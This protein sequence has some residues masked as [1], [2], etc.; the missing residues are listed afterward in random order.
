MEQRYN[1]LEISSAN[2]RRM[3]GYAATYNTASNPDALP[4]REKIAP[5]AFRSVLRNS[6]AVMLLNHDASSIL[7]RQSA[8][9]LRLS[10][11]E[12]GLR[13]ECDLPESPLGENVRAACAR[14]DLRECSFGFVVDQDDW[15][16]SDGEAMRTI[17]SFRSLSDC[18]LVT[19]PAYPGTSAMVRSMFPGGIPA[20]IRSRFPEM[21]KRSPKENRIA[22]RDKKF[23]GY[24]FGQVSAEQ[25]A[26]EDRAVNDYFGRP[27]SQQYQGGDLSGGTTSG[28]AGGFTV[29]AE[30]WSQ[31]KNAIAQTSGSL[32]DPNVVTLDDSGDYSL[33]GKV[34][35][36]WNL[37]ATKAVRV[38]DST[39]TDPNS[40]TA[41]PSY[42]KFTTGFLYRI[43]LPIAVELEDDT[44]GTIRTA[45]ANAFGEAMARGISAD[46]INGTGNGQ[47]QGLLTGAKNVQLSNTL[48][49]DWLYDLF[50]SVNAR[51]R[52]SSRAAFILT[53]STLNTI[54]RFTD[55]D[56]R[57]LLSLTDDGMRLLGKRVIVS[58]DIPDSSNTSPALAASVIFGDLSHY[59]VRVSR[60]TVTR[61]TESGLANG[62]GDISRGEC[63]LS[64]RMRCDATVHDASNGVVPPL[65]YSTYTQ[66]QFAPGLAVN[67]SF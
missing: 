66:T 12:R 47:P 4:W 39:Q 36:G 67:T 31:V 11:D 62:L 56:G 17:R 65:V 2:G 13:F 14:G 25:M 55:A 3:S 33:R 22:K 64:A 29:P 26:E 58:P 24:T 42:A 41:P 48:S 35:P 7:G 21:A 8:G 61:T 16:E 37:T 6:D 60:M 51:L 1:S 38:G 27:V 43:S 20:E 57:P 10:E 18:S 30:F 54:R 9:T 5:G 45:L 53:D 44:Q 32:L 40:Y 52:E 23:Y 28:I 63:L 19:F 15:D 59:I 50:F 46:L 34:F 49:V